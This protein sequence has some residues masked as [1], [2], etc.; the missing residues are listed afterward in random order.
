MLRED[1][2]LSGR[3]PSKV[4]G[5]NMN[6]GGHLHAIR[7]IYTWLVVFMYSTKHPFTPEGR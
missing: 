6:H 7:L 4:V 1:L 2:D 5:W 3:H